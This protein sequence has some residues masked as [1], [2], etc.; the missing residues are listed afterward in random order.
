[1]SKITL[2]KLKKKKK[3]FHYSENLLNY[4][5]YLLLKKIYY[6][7]NNDFKCSK[8]EMRK[9]KT[10]KVDFPNFEP[11][12]AK[13]PYFE[14]PKVEIPNHKFTTYAQQVRNFL[15]L[16]SGSG[17]NRKIEFYLCPLSPSLRIFSTPY[18]LIVCTSSLHNWAEQKFKHSSDLFIYTVTICHRLNRARISFICW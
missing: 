17:T 11:P 9:S 16:R 15:N 18:W 5:R 4:C 3:V 8:A 14:H 10:P 2:S 1:M 13:I 12:K 6:V 7:Q